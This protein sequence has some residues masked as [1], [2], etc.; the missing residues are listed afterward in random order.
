MTFR[1]RLTDVGRDLMPLEALTCTRCGSADVKEVKPKTYFCNYCDTVFKQVD[2]NSITVAHSP[3]FCL[4]GNLVTVQCQ[5]CHASICNDC[6]AAKPHPSILMGLPTVGFGYLLANQSRWSLVADGGLTRP[7][8]HSVGQPL[9]PIL[10]ALKLLTWLSATQGDL[11]HVCL[12]CLAPAVA[13]TAA[14][15]ADGAMC[16]EPVCGNRT[17]RR[18]DC[19]HAAYCDRH[20]HSRVITKFYFKWTDRVTS[21]DLWSQ[22]AMCGR[23]SCEARLWVGNTCTELYFKT[24][25]RYDDYPSYWVPAKPWEPKHVWSKTVTSG[26]RRRAAKIGKEL[27]S[28]LAEGDCQLERVRATCANYMIYDNRSSIAPAAA[29]G[30]VGTR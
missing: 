29:P 6:D 26:A 2:P 24:L 12:D 25:A 16:E 17:R 8:P 3:T 9:T 27:V 23:C 5:F 21:E 15:I 22:G 13:E 1:Q 19:C 20:V 4:C 28:A 18:C 11:R 14:Q 7:R 30:V 10:P